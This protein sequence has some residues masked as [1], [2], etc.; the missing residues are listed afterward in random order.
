MKGRRWLQALPIPIH[1]RVGLTDFAVIKFVRLF[2]TLMRNV[3]R[4]LCIIAFVA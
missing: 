4:T 2:H 1:E 3:V